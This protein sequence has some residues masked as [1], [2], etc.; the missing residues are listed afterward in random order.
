MPYLDLPSPRLHYRI[1]EV[2]PDGVAHGLSGMPPGPYDLADLGGH[3]IAHRQRRGLGGADPGGGARRA[4]RPARCDGRT[5][6]RA[7][8]T[9]QSVGIARPVLAVSGADDPVC[10]PAALE[11]LARA[12]RYGRHRML[13]GRHLVS[14][15]SAPAF[16]ALLRDF[17]TEAPVAAWRAG[18]VRTGFPAAPRSGRNRRYWR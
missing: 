8:L 2:E 4:W 6:A 9:A 17:L 13:P 18:P 7:N 16:N 12:V 14:V 15:Q 3:V 1:H 5:L 10:P 11:T